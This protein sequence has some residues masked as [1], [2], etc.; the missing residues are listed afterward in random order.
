MIWI[1]RKVRSLPFRLI[2]ITLL[3]INVFIDYCKKSLNEI[4]LSLKKQLF[5]QADRKVEYI[6]IVR[7]AK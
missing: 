7:F 3:D 4:H 2:L 5:V 6:G 1:V